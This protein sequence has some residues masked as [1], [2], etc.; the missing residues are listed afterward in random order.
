MTLAC[1]GPTTAATFAARLLWDK[2]LVAG[3]QRSPFF[4]EHLRSVATVKAASKI[5]PAAPK[6]PTA[7]HLVHEQLP[8]HGAA[9]VK[10]IKEPEEWAAAAAM[11]VEEVVQGL[12][13]R[14]LRQDEPFMSAGLDSLGAAHPAP[15]FHLLIKVMLTEDKRP[16]SKACFTKSRFEDHRPSH[17]VSA[18]LASCLAATRGHGAQA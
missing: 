9:A 1:V 17:K 10:S 16:Q 15:F 14:P 13:G 12:L 6:A 11:L 4:M 3:R 2:L 7:T 18:V 8:R 5:A